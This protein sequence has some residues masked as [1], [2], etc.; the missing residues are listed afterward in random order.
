MQELDAF[1]D[2]D[3]KLRLTI[4]DTVT[5]HADGRLTFNPGAIQNLRSDEIR[6]D[7]DVNR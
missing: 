2:F 6:E 3:E 7:S 5:V 1:A 4:I